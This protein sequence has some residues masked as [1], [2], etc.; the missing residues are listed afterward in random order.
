MITWRNHGFDSYSADFNG[1]SLSV[2]SDPYYGYR[3]AV[4]F[5]D[6]SQETGF[7]PFLNSAQDA[8]AKMAALQQADS[9]ET[10]TL[11]L[12]VRDDY[13]DCDTG[14]TRLM[15]G[16]TVQISPR[17]NNWF[18]T[19]RTPHEALRLRSRQWPVRILRAETTT[20]NLRGE[21]PGEVAA[22]S[23]HLLEEV[24]LSELFGPLGQQILA[25]LDRLG[26]YRWQA[27][28]PA[29]HELAVNL[30]HEHLRRL[31]RFGFTD[32][33]QVLIHH[34]PLS[35][36]A[37]LIVPE[38]DQNRLPALGRAV[39]AAQT[40]AQNA[41]LSDHYNLAVS[42]ASDRVNVLLQTVQWDPNESDP[43]SEASII[44][45]VA[46]GQ[47]ARDVSWSIGWL[48]VP[49]LPENPFEPLAQLWELG[50]YPIGIVN[51]TFFVFACPRLDT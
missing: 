28:D 44:S 7:A 2:W 48:A 21:Q 20:S 6:G 50:Y 14:I 1:C 43:L 40:A 37:D 25:A 3:W 16:S 45:A 36:C 32:R 49:G 23:L 39:E 24:P 9:T 51:N 26:V 46:K 11:Y 17:G 27:P 35:Q 38:R 15:P 10:V 13:T 12:P 47:A 8:A 41:G 22:V 29:T 31:A 30:A 42:V 19:A 33:P 4:T 34:A 5:L 18:R